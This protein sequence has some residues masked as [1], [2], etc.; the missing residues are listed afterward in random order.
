MGVPPFYLVKEE[1]QPKVP[2][3]MPAN[4]PH[5]LNDYF[6]VLEGGDGY[7]VISEGKNDI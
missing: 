5:E 4:L 1:Y 2:M 6:I 3:S 7:R